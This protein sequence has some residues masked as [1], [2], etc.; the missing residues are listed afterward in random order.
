MLTDKER[1]EVKNILRKAEA[2]EANGLFEQ[3][4]RHV[5]IHKQVFATYQLRDGALHYCG[6]IANENGWTP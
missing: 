4:D 3:A 1:A 5:A 2:F 6:Y